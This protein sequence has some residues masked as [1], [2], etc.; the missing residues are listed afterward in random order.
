M[1]AVAVV[2]MMRLLTF[3]GKVAGDEVNQGIDWFV[4]GISWRFM[5]FDIRIVA[6]SVQFIV[7]GAAPIVCCVETAIIISIVFM[8]M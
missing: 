1:S 5:F 6:F 8:G 7:L 2:I 3:V 4:S